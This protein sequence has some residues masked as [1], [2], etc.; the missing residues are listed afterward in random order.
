V[1]DEQADNECLAVIPARSG[2]KRI[3]GKNLKNFCGKPIIEYSIESAIQSKVFSRIIVSTDHPDIAAVAIKAGAEV[4]FLRDSRLSDDLTNTDQVVVDAISRLSVLGSEYTY[5]ACIYATTPMLAP[6]DIASGLEALK[7][8]SSDF[9]L[10]VNRLR[11]PV[12]RTYQIGAEGTLKLRDPSAYHI[13]SQDL[14]DSFADS[15]QFYWGTQKGWRDLAAKGMESP[16]FFELPWHKSLDLD[17]LE[18]WD[19]A[20]K[21]YNALYK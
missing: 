21:I 18:D 17:T 14:P 3:P 6:T 5:T 11:F 15:G 8:R 20:E 16:T 4:P 10:A 9:L 12:E 2:S 13:R 19:M 1:K 7:S